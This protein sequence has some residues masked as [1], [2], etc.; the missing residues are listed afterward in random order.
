MTI[1]ANHESRRDTAPARNAGSAKGEPPKPLEPDQNVVRFFD[2]PHC[3]GRG[4]FLIN[5]FATGGSNGAGGIR[6]MTQCLTCV[7]AKEHFE[8]HG[9]LPEDLL[10]NVTGELR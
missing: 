8:A 5:P 6:N 10:Q 3:N 4:W 1:H 9:E 7:R 2:C